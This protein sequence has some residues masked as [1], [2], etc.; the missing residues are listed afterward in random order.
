MYKK[1]PELNY[2]GRLLTEKYYLDLMERT[3]CL[4][5]QS[6]KE[7]YEHLIQTH[8][9]LIKRASLGHIASYLGISQETL[10]RIRAKNNPSCFLTFIK[11]RFNLK[12]DFWFCISNRNHRTKF[13]DY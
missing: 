12:C 3:Y 9:Q 10:S 6:A 2:L 8:P 1:Y 7:S 5:F 13:T 11:L 4:Q